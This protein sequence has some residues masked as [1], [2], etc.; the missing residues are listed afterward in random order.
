MTT[1]E[2]AE[3]L[4]TDANI[5]VTYSVSFD[6]PV[7]SFD[8][9]N[10]SVVGGTAPKSVTLEFDTNNQIIGATF[11]VVAADGSTADLVVTVSGV[12]DLA[13]NDAAEVDAAPVAVYT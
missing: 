7:Q 12:K 2:S 1:V 5:A 10:V 8:T 9:S 4:T 11:D 6:E 3:A 13:G